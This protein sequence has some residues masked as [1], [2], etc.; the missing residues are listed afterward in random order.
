MSDELRAAAERFS[1]WVDTPR[2]RI[3]GSVDQEQI[4]GDAYELA[5]AYLAEHPADDAEPVTADWLRGLGFVRGQ[6]AAADDNLTLRAGGVELTRWHRRGV[7]AVEWSVQ[8]A[9]DGADWL[10]PC[11][12]PATR[13]HVRRLLAALGIT[14][15]EPR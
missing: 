7:P 4:D 8:T 9:E 12:R 10:P 6:Q 14:P 13:G 3:V 2:V 15:G 5:A 1:K 11:L